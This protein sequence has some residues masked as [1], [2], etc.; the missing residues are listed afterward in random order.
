MKFRIEVDTEEE[1]NLFV[2]VMRD[3]PTRKK[4]QVQ[5]RKQ[6]LEETQLN[7]NLESAKENNFDLTT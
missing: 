7:R 3:N 4:R 2:K 5:P 6:Q 1:A